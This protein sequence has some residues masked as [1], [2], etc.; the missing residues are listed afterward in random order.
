VVSVTI[1]GVASDGSL[2]KT[3]AVLFAGAVIWIEE[4]ESKRIVTSKV[5]VKATP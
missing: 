4:A 3:L 2:M 1:R 5:V